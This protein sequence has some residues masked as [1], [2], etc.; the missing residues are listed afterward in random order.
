[1]KATGFFHRSEKMAEYPPPEF[2]SGTLFRKQLILCAFP[3]CMKKIR[4]RSQNTC[5]PQLAEAA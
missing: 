3:G 2:L 1:M 5:T 4:E